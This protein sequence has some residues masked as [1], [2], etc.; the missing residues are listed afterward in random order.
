MCANVCRASTEGIEIEE[1]CPDGEITFSVWDFGGQVRFVSLYNTC[2][3][4]FRLRS[5][6]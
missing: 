6:D 4:S 1:W 3:C 2:R 5:P